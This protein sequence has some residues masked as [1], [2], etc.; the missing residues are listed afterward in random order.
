M[1]DLA[2]NKVLSII[3]FNS[4]PSL[5]SMVRCALCVLI[6]GALY[7]GCDESL[8]APYSARVSECFFVFTSFR[9]PTP[10]WYAARWCLWPATRVQLATRWHWIRSATARYGRFCLLNIVIHYSLRGLWAR[11]WPATRVPTATTAWIWGSAT[12][13]LV[14]LLPCATFLDVIQPQLIAVILH[15]VYILGAH[16]ALSTLYRD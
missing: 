8:P 14:S 15:R 11:I 9:P 12:T 2:S 3:T 16:C 7:T 13:R 6:P 10:E 4:V 1:P 5:C